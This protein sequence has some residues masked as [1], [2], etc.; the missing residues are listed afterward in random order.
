[1]TFLQNKTEPYKIRKEDQ[2]IRGRFLPEKDGERT[3]SDESPGIAAGERVSKDQK[4]S[5]SPAK[6]GLTPPGTI[7]VSG[8][9]KARVP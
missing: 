4:F 6:D 9:S 7:F 5:N 1:M 2:L 3:L 8:S